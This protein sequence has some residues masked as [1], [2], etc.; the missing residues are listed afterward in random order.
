MTI[1]PIKKLGE[2][3]ERITESVLPTKYPDREFNFIG[4]ENIE[5]NTGKI[6]NAGSTKGKFIKS[7]KT[8]FIKNDVLYGKLRPYLNKVW[9]AEFDGICSTDIWV[10]RAKEEVILS[11]LLWAILQ[12]SS[13]VQK[14]SASMAG[15]NLPRAN[16]T[17]F[18]NIKIPLP[19]LK[20]Q[21]QIVERMDKIAEAQKL[22]N[23]LIQ[24]SDELFQ[25]LLHQ[26][27]NPAGKNWETKKLE[28]LVENV[29]I[30]PF[31]S[32]LKIAELSDTG[33]VRVLFIENVVNNK[34]EFAKEKYISEE[35]YKE[36]KV[37]T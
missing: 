10:L 28:T 27:L 13:I 16:K 34:F 18:D 36:L 19:P 1:W 14:S 33:P 6:I 37:Y 24:K 23:K 25:S 5:S 3:F 31:G 29:K 17:V 32:A 15:A 7:T 2:I 8:V 22:N 11:Q 4:L 9:L 26:E 35:K 21:K 12:Q 20:I 30:G